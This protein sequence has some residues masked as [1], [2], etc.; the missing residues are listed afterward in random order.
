MR[1]NSPN[2]N[3]E[4]STSAG[5]VPSHPTRSTSSKHLPVRMPRPC[6]VTSGAFSDQSSTNCSRSILRRT[7]AWPESSGND[8]AGRV[9]EFPGAVAIAP[10]RPLIIWM[11]DEDA[12]GQVDRGITRWHARV[13]WTLP[14]WNWRGLV[15]GKLLVLSPSEVPQGRHMP[16]VAGPTATS[17]CDSRRRAAAFGGILR[18]IRSDSMIRGGQSW[19]VSHERD[20]GRDRFDGGG[21]AT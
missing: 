15:L 20:R 16:H 4:S 12:P 17:R 7:F 11:G 8:R 18:G 14:I 10:R 13:P 21:T 3:A 5:G 2:L 19:I 6:L 1:S 9:P